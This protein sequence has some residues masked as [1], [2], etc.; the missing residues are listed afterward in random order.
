MPDLNELIANLRTLEAAATPGEWEIRYGGNFTEIGAA[1]FKEYCDS[2]SDSATP[3]KIGE[4]ACWHRPLKQSRKDGDFIVALHNALPALLAALEYHRKFES[5]YPFL[6]A[7]AKELAGVGCTTIAEALE[8]L[9]TA[10]IHNDESLEVKQQEF[11]RFLWLNHGCPFG[12]RYGDDGEMQC[13][14]VGCFLD[15]RRL[16]IEQLW[17]GVISRFQQQISDKASLASQLQA[18]EV[19]LLSISEQLEAE[20]QERADIVTELNSAVAQVA[21]LTAE[22]NDLTIRLTECKKL[23]FQAADDALV[24]HAERAKLHADLAIDEQSLDC[25]AAGS[26]VLVPKVRME[27]LAEARREIARLL[28]AL[29]QIATMEAGR[30]I[31][32]PLHGA[33]MAQAFE[34]T[35]KIARIA[36]EGK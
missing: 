9:A 12:G 2:N 1:G 29:S 32:G 6:L 11:R 26:V 4:T 30:S 3:L 24:V 17:S 16:P 20:R 8:W 33:G 34:H 22:R 15:F 27:E 31:I 28:D 13:N 36:L 7:R 10:R 19:I 21:D 5:S 25:I 23:Y 14:N 35:A 18:K